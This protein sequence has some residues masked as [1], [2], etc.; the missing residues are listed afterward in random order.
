MEKQDRKF[1]LKY[2]LTVMV[3]TAIVTALVVSAVYGTMLF[4]NKDIKVY[5]KFKEISQIIQDKYL[6][7]YD[8]DQLVDMSLKGLVAG[9]GDPYS[10]YLDKD[11]LEQRE[12]ML[13]N[14]YVGIGIEAA[15]DKE[16]NLVTVVSIIEGGP[17]QSAGLQP[18]DKIIE[19]NGENVAGQNINDVTGKLKNG[20][21]DEEI[22]LVVMRSN[23]RVD[24]S[25]KREKVEYISIKA[26]LLEDGIGYIRITTFNENTDEKFT[27]AIKSLEQQG[28]KRFILDVRNN[29]GGLVDSAKNIADLFIDDGLLFYTQDKNGNRKEYEADHK[30]EN[31]DKIIVLMNGNSA[32]ASELLTGALKDHGAAVTMGEKTFGKGIIQ[33]MLSLGKDYGIVLTTEEYYTPNGNQIHKA[34]IEPDIQGITPEG[35]YN[36]IGDLAK[37]SLLQKAVAEIKK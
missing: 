18:N 1:L 25:V 4:A 36:S 13:N 9:L 21:V 11:D 37:D 6:F 14:G 19:I 16:D 35:E 2:G 7:P 29:G 28:A 8:E 17:A 33:S 12:T 34:G 31:Y 27:E 23:E 3:V 20:S 26:A 22:Q 30:K 10:A 5:N 24:I 32:S 15:V